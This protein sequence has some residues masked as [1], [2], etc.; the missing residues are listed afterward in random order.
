MLQNSHIYKNE[1]I[2]LNTDWLNNI[3]GSSGSLIKE[4]EL[5]DPISEHLSNDNDEANFVGGSHSAEA[6]TTEN[7]DTNV[8]ISNSHN[9]NVQKPSDVEHT[10]TDI[11]NDK[12]ELINMNE[13]DEDLNAIHHDTLLYKEDL[14]HADPKSFPHELIF[15]PGEGHRPMSIFQDTDVEYLAFS[16][17]FCGQR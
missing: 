10:N 1:N 4:V 8:G 6:M 9:D 7:N 2:Q 3:S 5:F 17:T 15:A 12:I 11:N 13:V 14:P 16:T